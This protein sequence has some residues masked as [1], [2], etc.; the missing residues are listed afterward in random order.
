MSY[1]HKNMDILETKLDSINE[2]E[3]YYEDEHRVAILIVKDRLTKKLDFYRQIAKFK[4]VRA[5]KHIYG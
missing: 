4:S 3:Q 5:I 2:M 1:A